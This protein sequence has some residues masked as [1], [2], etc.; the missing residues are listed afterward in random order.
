[1]VNHFPSA[2]PANHHP[3]LRGRYKMNYQLHLRLDN[4]LSGR[5]IALHHFDMTFDGRGFVIQ[6]CR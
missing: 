5:N 3:L 4:C 1:M 2:Y 6:G